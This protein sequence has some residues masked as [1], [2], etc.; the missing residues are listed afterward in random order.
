MGREAQS[1]IGTWS[2]G[3]TAGLK[4]PACQNITFVPI[5]VSVLDQLSDSLSEF[6]VPPFT[7]TGQVAITGNKPDMLQFFRHGGGNRDDS[8][9]A[10]L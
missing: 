7:L 9:R 2:K 1:C 10:C 8:L 4:R 3:D 6:G 5:L